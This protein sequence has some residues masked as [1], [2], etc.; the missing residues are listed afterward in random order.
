M[1]KLLTILLISILVCTGCK[2]EDLTTRD[3]KNIK[4]ALVN[5]DIDQ[6]RKEINSLCEEIASTPAIGGMRTP[7]QFQDELVKALNKCLLAENLCYFCI[8]TLPEQSE[9]RIS[10]DGVSRILDIS[11]NNSN[12]KLEF[13]SMHN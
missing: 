4:T 7:I 12:Q 11:Y 10:A 9:I 1:A 3:C 13:R 8:Q 2:K 6:M 5:N